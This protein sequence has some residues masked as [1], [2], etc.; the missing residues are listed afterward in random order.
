MEDEKFRNAQIMVGPMKR[1][2]IHD[3]WPIDEK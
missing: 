1:L 2:T 3:F